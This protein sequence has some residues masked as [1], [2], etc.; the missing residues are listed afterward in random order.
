MTAA[1]FLDPRAARDARLPLVPVPVGAVVL[2]EDG[3]QFRVRSDGGLDTVIQGGRP[4]GGIAED[5]CA[6]RRTPP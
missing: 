2:T 5:A 6:R 4:H 3:Q 1:L